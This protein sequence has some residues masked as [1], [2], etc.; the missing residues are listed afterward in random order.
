MKKRFMLAIFLIAIALAST[1]VGVKAANLLT[2]TAKPDQNLYDMYSP[3]TLNEG[4]VYTTYEGPGYPSDGLV[5][6]QILDSNGATMVIRTLSTGGSPP[7]TD[8]NITTTIT[9]AYL[10]N[11]AENQISSV[12]IPSAT[13]TIIPMFYFTVSNLLNTMQSVLVTFN[14]YDS[15][16]VPIA[17]ASQ[18]VAM[19]ASSSEEALI[20]FNIPSFAHYGTA[21]AY[22][23]VY[24]TWPSKGGVPLG[25]EYAFQFTISGGTPFQG[26]PSTTSSTN[27]DNHNFNMVFRL[28]K[29][30]AS[31]TYTAYSTTNY[32]SLTTSAT[33][34]FNVKLL[35]DF[36]GEGNVNFGDVSYFVTAYI[37]Y[38]SSA[39]TYNGQIDFLNAGTISFAD[40]LLFVQYYILYYSS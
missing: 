31:G 24:S 26:T 33:T 29:T 20:D 32:Q 2:L 39:H 11:G 21:Y 3:V 25:E 12:S 18:N 5:G 34:T 19:G 38:F 40:V 30:C 8:V 13:N 27:Q 22:V 15:N 10:S 28:P 6:F 37:A 36:L 7:F 1:M 14:V 35:D 23:D 16:G 9:Q 4:L 17:V